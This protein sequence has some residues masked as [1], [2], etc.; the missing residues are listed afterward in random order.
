MVFGSLL[1]TPFME[2][3]LSMTRW[4]PPQVWV[5]YPARPE[6][7]EDALFFGESGFLKATILTTTT[8]IF[9]GFVM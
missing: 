7:S 4:L 5:V 2:T 9:V 6:V 1:G 8:I 3:H